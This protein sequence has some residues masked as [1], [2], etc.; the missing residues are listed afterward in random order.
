S[1]VTILRGF[2]AIKKTRDLP[3]AILAVW[4][5]RVRIPY[6][7]P[8]EIYENTLFPKDNGNSVFRLLSDLIQ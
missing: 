5:S 7:P 2:L 4:G 1:K 6:A 8:Y 3:V